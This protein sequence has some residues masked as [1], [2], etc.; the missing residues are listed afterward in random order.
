MDWEFGTVLWSMLVFF[1]WFTAIWMFLV[2]FA[3]IIRRDLSGWAKAGWIVL[4]VVLPFI[5]IVI[6]IVARP[7]GTAD[8]FY[9]M[10][11]G[12]RAQRSPAE[13]IGR[14]GSLYDQGKITTDEF[15]QIKARALA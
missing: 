14:A 9:P 4:I 12:S 10:T 15:E 11:T 13:E 1:F 7:R 2:V 3:D 8:D 6:Y 5:G